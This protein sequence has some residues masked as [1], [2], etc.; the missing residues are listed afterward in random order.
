MA[1]KILIKKVVT[2][3]YSA[4][5]SGSDLGSLFV[6]LF[7]IIVKGLADNASTIVILIVVALIATLG[8][9]ALK[10]IFGTIKILR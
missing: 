9:R 6:D 3:A 5:Y 2:M 4:T 8:A 7:S 10:G 1:V